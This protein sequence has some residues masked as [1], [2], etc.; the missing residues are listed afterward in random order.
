MRLLGVLLVTACVTPTRQHPP[1]DSPDSSPALAPVAA[2]PRPSDGDPSGVLAAPDDRCP[3]EPETRNGYQDDDGC[4][5]ELPAD[6]A[7]VTGVLVGVGF[8]IDKDHLRPESFALLDRVAEVLRRYPAVRF[9]VTNHQDATN[10]PEYGRCLTCRRADMV[11][12][13]L[14]E[15]GVDARQLQARG[16]G[17]DVPLDTNKTAA[18]RAKNRRTELTIVRP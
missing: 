4:P 7:A 8:D 1:P 12:R 6:L 2:A 10:G 14:V 18:G 9:E 11:K 16:M 3:A 15:H 13:Y 17:S 5:D